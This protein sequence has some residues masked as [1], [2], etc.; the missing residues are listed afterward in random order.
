MYNI[1]VI[2]VGN[3]KLP[4]DDVLASKHVGASYIYIYVII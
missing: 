2:L 3:R 1:Y 4:D